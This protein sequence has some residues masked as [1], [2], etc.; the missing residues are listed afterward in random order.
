MLTELIDE[1][2]FSRNPDERL[3][4]AALIAATPYRQ[5]LADAV[6]ERLVRG[7]TRDELLVERG[8]GL[9]NKLHVTTHRGLVRT[10]LLD[11]SLSARNRHAAAWASTHNP[12]RLDLSVWRAI[13]VTQTALVRSRP[14]PLDDDIVR[15]LVYS[16]GTDA[17]L[18]LLREMRA[19]SRL[20]QRVRDVAAWWMRV[21]RPT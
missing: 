10:L 16:V 12:G 20:S 15:G 13:I 3:Y 6:A 9:L 2:M 19:D 17:H 1:A 7:D 14:S 18:S 5:P 8:L 21:V 11:P 4:A